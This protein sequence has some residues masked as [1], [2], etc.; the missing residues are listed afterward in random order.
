[1]CCYGIFVHYH[2]ISQDIA[3]FF[4]F[5]WLVI[6]IGSFATGIPTSL[7]KYIQAKVSQSRLDEALAIKTNTLINHNLSVKINNLPLLQKINNL[8]FRGYNDSKTKDDI[9]KICLDSDLV[10]ICCGKS[11]TIQGSFLENISF[12]TQQHTDSYQIK[13][14]FELSTLTD[15]FEF[16]KID[17]IDLSTNTLSTGQHARL[18]IARIIYQ[19]KNENIIFDVTQYLD[20]LT[21]DRLKNKLIKSSQK[22]VFI[23][24]IGIN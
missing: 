18:G 22:F 23:D 9:L 17:K 15:D 20:P 4:E 7:Q 24:P 12:K 8:E 16:K 6:M 5:L 3:L 13:K 10:G 11:E 19:N 21:L 14:A 2:W 1:M